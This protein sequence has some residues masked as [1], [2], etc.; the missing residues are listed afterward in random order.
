M[1]LNSCLNLTISIFILI[2]SVAFPL[3]V[4][5]QRYNFTSFTIAD[6]LPNNQI[7]KVMQAINGELW[8][9]TMTGACRYDGHS[10]IKFDQDNILSR[11]AVKSIFQ[12]SEGNIWFGMIRKGLC[13]YDGTSYRFFTTN[14]GLLSDIVNSVTEDKKGNIWIGTSDGLNKFDGKSFSSYT[15]DKGL[16]NNDIFSIRLDY[17]GNLIIATIG[18]ISFFDYTTFKNYSADNGLANDIVYRAIQSIDKKIWIGTYS[19]ISE[20][21]GKEFKNYTSLN[22]LVNDKIQDIIQSSNNQLWFATYG[23]GVYY[24]DNNQF[25]NLNTV[26]GLSNNTVMSII[27]DREGNYWFGTQNGLCK[28]SGDRFTTFTIEDGLSSNTI[29]STYVDK[30]GKIWFGT[31]GSG[32][33]SFN[34]SS[35][36]SFS[37]N[38]GLRS[39][40]IRDVT[41]DYNNNYWLSTTSG[42]AL[43]NNSANGISYPVAYLNDFVIYTILVANDST[44]YFGTDRGVFVKRKSRLTKIG[45]FNGLVD[46]KV[47]VLFEDHSGVIWVGTLAGLYYLNGSSAISFNE[48]YKIPKA[49][50]TSVIEDAEHNM[51]ISTYDFGLL[52]YSPTNQ[53]NPV[54]ALSKKNGLNNNRILCSILDKNQNL[55]LGTPEGTDCINWP[56]LVKENKIIINHFDKSNGF[57]GGETNTV[58][59]DKEGHLWFGTVNGV[60]KYNLKS[61]ISR[62]KVPLVAITNIQL[63]LKNVDWEKRKLPISSRSGL[64]ENLELKY[65]DNYLSFFFSGIYLTAPSE[66]HYRFML[67]GFDADWS[68]PSRQAVANYSNLS[69]GEYVFKVKASAN[70][71]DWS[72]QVTYSFVI[73]PPFWKTP[74]AYIFYAIAIAASIWLFL[75]IRTRN[76][77]HS[78][79]QLRKKVDLRTRELNAKN[80][81]LEKLSLVASETDNAVMIFDAYKKL[82]WIN[83]GYTRMT[84]FTLEEI[85]D[86]G[87]KY[88]S[89]FY[90]DADT[91]QIVEKCIAEKKSSVFE[92]QMFKKSGESLWISSTLNPIFGVDGILKNIVVIDTNITYRK[93]MEEQIKNSLQEK[94][95]LL[96]E[97]HHRVKNNLQIIISLFNLQSN[98]LKDSQAFQALKEGQDRIKS[99][100]L[101]HERFYESEGMT[102][103]DFDDYIRRLTENLFLSF[104]IDLEKIKLVIDSDKIALDIDSAVPCGLIINELVSN[105]LKHAF[106]NN[107]HGQVTIDFH[108]TDS[109]KYRL[110]ISD[111]GIG[112]P[113]YFNIH[114]TE[115]LGMQL[116]TALADQLDGTIEADL[117]KG[118]KFI[119]EFGKT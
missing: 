102:R 79:I 111:D 119:I 95:L 96:K 63:F 117:R 25:I 74:L 84:G 70:L 89:E 112:L 53:S 37:S 83:E 107:G 105:S 116:V 22:G 73:T 81:E 8:I 26:N 40:T 87:G 68:P 57:F 19:G 21:D 82:E 72:N 13:R 35:F 60:I 100:A 20:F 46:D 47:R 14:D 106:N 9:G 17:E 29:L 48:K 50:V 2:S 49:P 115:S 7:N 98:Y 104:K 92:S 38:E 61:G 59:E 10:F 76:L 5:S 66:V 93:M 77:K 80:I 32:L 62:Q 11:N 51:I 86:P 4:C 31:L 69:A 34:D 6:G 1:K 101:I 36:K 23:G 54:T 94:G 97:I 56:I 43:L 118:T 33:N 52:K 24:L 42:P 55:W 75:K 88:F 67:E 41:S 103:I 99:M 44:I 71:N 15:T 45:V 110:E 91:K 64:P 109:K 18:G 113:E 12:D 30:S 27:E 65:Y 28:Y 90:K 108:S 114:T 3:K 85:T 39:S 16:I 78:Q 58:C